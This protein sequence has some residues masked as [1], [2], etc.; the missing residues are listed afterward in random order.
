MF[1][2]TTLE[3]ARQYRSEQI[4]A[5]EQSRL[6]AQFKSTRRRHAVLAALR[7]FVIDVASRPARKVRI[8]P[9]T[10]PTKQPLS[11]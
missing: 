8:S 10:P 6:A 5:A 7:R 11:R 3:M 4:L 2:P 9:L 1:S